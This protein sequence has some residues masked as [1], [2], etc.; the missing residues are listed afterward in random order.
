M[1]PSL[2][3]L[4]MSD[5][6]INEDDFYQLFGN[7]S[8]LRSLD[9]SGTNILNIAGISRLKQLEVLALRDFSIATYTELKDLF[10]LKHLRVLD[11]SQTR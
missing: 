5:V 10:N 3:H 6:H 9:I 8:N 2:T 7:F 1:L 4:T 11:V